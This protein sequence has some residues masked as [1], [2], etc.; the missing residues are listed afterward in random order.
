LTTDGNEGVR[1]LLETELALEGDKV[2]V[3][4]NGPA[5]LR[6]IKEKNPDLVI[7]DIKMPDMHRL[8]V[9]E[10]IRKENKR[11]SEPLKLDKVG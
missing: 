3:A 7:L 5:V 2:V 10:A 4:K 11:W 6:K 1:L 8:K 9:L